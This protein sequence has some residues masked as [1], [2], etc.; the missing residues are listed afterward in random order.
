MEKSR[1]G[2]RPIRIKPRAN[3]IASTPKPDIAR[4]RAFIRIDI[5]DVRHRRAE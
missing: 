4:V 5:N 3:D 2:L 1:E